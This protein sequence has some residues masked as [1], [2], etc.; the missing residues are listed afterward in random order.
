MGEK[1]DLL[2]SF[3]IALWTTVLLFSMFYMP[4]IAAELV[5]KDT[6][7]AGNL[8]WKGWELVAYVEGHYYSGASE[9]HYTY[10]R[11]DVKSLWPF[12]WINYAESSYKGYRNGELAYNFTGEQF[13]WTFDMEIDNIPVDIATTWVGAEFEN[14]WGTFWRETE[15]AVIVIT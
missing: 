7:K 15:E 12:V 9:F 10:H 5:K 8:G 3:C 14:I 1:K 11:S 13:D 4:A 6:E 2:I